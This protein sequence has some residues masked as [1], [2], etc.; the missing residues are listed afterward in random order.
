MLLREVFIEEDCIDV[1][2]NCRVDR[3]RVE[4]C[5]SDAVIEIPGSDTHKFGVPNVSN[6]LPLEAVRCI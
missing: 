3:F 2:R 6:Q 4:A 5:H 1:E